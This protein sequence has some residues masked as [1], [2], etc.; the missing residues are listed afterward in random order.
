M[1][2]THLTVGVVGISAFG[3][4]I[5]R[6]R[7]GR[8][9]IAAAHAWMSPSLE[10]RARGE[11]SICGAD[12]DTVTMAVESARD[13]LIDVSR[14]NIGALYL[15]TTTAPFADRLNSAIVAAALRLRDDAASADITGSLRAALQAL[16]AG[17]SHV[18]AHG[19]MALCVGSDRRRTA[20]ASALEMSTGHAA[21]AVLLAPGPGVA[22][23]L[24]SARLTVDF[25]DHF[26]G[27]GSEF[28]YTWEDR[29]TRDE[30]YLKIIP[31]V[32]SAALAD[33]GVGPGQVARFCLPAP[34]A[35]V[36]R[37]VAARVGIAA[38]NVQDS[39]DGDCGDSGAAHPILLLVAA[40]EEA[41][42]GQVIVCAGFGQG[43][44]AFVF[45]VTDAI[46]DYRSLGTGTRR[47]RSRRVS[48][49]YPRYL[50]LHDLLAVDRGIR[51][52]SDKGTALTAAYR[53]RDLLN[54][55]TG[56]RCRR[57][58]TC[59]I[60][61]ARMCAN[62]DCRAVD[63]QD[64][65]CF[66]DSKA[67][68]VSWSADQLTYTP[69]PPAYYGMVDFEE[70]GRLMMDFADTVDGSLEVGAEMRMVFRAKDFDARRGFTRYFWKAAPAAAPTEA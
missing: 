24:G 65:H 52:E 4:Y 46:T 2:G 6:L 59:Q 63:S 55:L 3:A 15:G 44:Q 64:P 18:R 50:A 20:P 40:L 28:D 27:E 70:G 67:R 13:A 12:E 22:E 66:A 31:P 17:A 58:G 19:T 57:C 23:L 47:W 16:D 26:R 62:P 8:A 54:E 21:A 7:V 49:S 30:G 36:D 10:A 68:V 33:A 48:C 5:P 69:D 51:A 9:E 41:M 56:G 25:V 14:E 53:H 38:E 34:F 45:K 37:A 11:R 42:P 1:G 29:W 32:V 61:R 60:P 39:L 43:A 35:R